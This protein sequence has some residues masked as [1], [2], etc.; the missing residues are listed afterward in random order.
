M[1]RPGTAGDP[2]NLGS[3]ARA[4][5]HSDARDRAI[6]NPHDTAVVDDFI[7]ALHQPGAKQVRDASTEHVQRQRLRDRE[8]RHDYAHLRDGR[9]TALAKLRQDGPRVF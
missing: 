8:L 2:L 4:V 1:A 7:R 3:R 6:A 9:R 5:P